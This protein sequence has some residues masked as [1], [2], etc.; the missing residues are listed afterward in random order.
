MTAETNGTS[1]PVGVLHVPADMGLDS[2]VREV[3]CLACGNR[4]TN[5]DQPLDTQDIE[6]FISAHPGHNIA[7]AEHAAPPVCRPPLPE[8]GPE[9]VDRSLPKKEESKP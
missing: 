2:P 5:V 4:I 6:A 1:H 7:V 9:L 8:P 3:A